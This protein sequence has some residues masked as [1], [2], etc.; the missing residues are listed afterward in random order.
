LGERGP[1]RLGFTANLPRGFQE[2]LGAIAKPDF[3]VILNEVKDLKSLKTLIAIS[4]PLL[5]V[6]LSIAKGLDI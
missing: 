1:G 3:T 4:K 5:S 6:T 2:R